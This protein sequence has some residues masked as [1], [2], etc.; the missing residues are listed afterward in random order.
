MKF[1]N[2]SCMAVL[3]AL[4]LSSCSNISNLVTNN[5][6]SNVTPNTQLPATLAESS[7]PWHNKV[8]ALK[9]LPNRYLNQSKVRDIPVEATRRFEQGLVLI[10]QQSWSEAQRLYLNLAE[11]YPLFSGVWLQLAQ[12]QQAQIATTGDV[13]AQQQALDLQN[14]YLD[15]AIK[16]NADNYVAHNKLAML[17]RQQGQFAQALRHYDL[18]LNS[19]PAFPEARLNRGILNDLYMGNKKAA[20]EDYQL[21]QAMLT[22]PSRQLKGWIFDVERQLQTQQQQ[23]NPTS[24][25]IKG[26]DQ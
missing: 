6:T 14:R 19:W 24:G 4:G 1:I 8:Q 9:A 21:Y 25:S 26:Q 22:E 3:M 17:L 15:N 23:Y 16:A 2:L 5:N 13:E 20:L 12:I 11:Q 7:D 10:N 18:A